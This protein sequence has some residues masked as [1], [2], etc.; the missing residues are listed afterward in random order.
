MADSA[1]VLRSAVPVLAGAVTALVLA[2]AAGGSRAAG[3]E[4]ALVT[5]ADGAT[6]LTSATL[7]SGPTLG[8]RIAWG[9]TLPG[10]TVVMTVRI[11]TDAALTQNVAENTF[12]C[13]ARSANCP[14]YFKPNRVYSGRYYWRVTLSGAVRVTSSTWSFVGVRQGGSGGE[15]RTKPSVQV[16]SGVAQ[17]GQTAFFSARVGDDRGFVRLR[18]TLT[19]RGHELARATAP[20]RPVAWARRQ[21]LFSNR[22]LSRALVRGAYRLCV[23]AW[24]RAGNATR[25]CAPYR[26]R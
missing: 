4:V 14:S 13:A 3:P 1:G 2:A 19:R 18:A 6:V 22:P 25:D 11:A 21:T 17:R 5:P 24:D 26:V 23:T 10:G 8:W 7:G 15:D 16:L 12:S 20:F 9:E